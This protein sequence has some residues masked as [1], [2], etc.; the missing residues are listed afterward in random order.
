MA[1]RTNEIKHLILQG[2]PTEAALARAL[3]WPRQRLN[4][5]T[6]GGRLPTIEEV[7]EIAQVTGLSVERLLHIFLRHKSPNG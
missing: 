6:T 2:Y 4:K 7:N 3:G 1:E 5:L